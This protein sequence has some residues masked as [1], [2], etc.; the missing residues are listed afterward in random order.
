MA[1]PAEPTRPKTVSDL[2]R[3]LERDVSPRVPEGTEAIAHGGTALTLLGIKDSTKDVDFAFR[4]RD[5]FDAVVKAL[6]T[7]GY[8]RT[9]EMSPVPGEEFLRL[10]NAAVV[11]DVVDVR[12]PT[13]NGWRLTGAVFRNAI[14]IPLGNVRLVRP[15]RDAV[16]LFKTYP[17]RETD[18]A[19]LRAILAKD[20]PDEARVIALFDEQDAIHRA[21]LLEETRHEPLINILELRVRFAASIGLLEPSERGRIPGIARHAR[22]R[23]RELRLRPGLSTL[24][25]RLRSE[26]VAKWEDILAASGDRLRQQLAVKKGPKRTAPSQTRRR[27]AR[28]PR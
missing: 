5:G 28:G 11:V 7:M 14:V 25:R 15:D 22:N 16:F 20:P 6:T 8:R 18:L 27:D 12:F 3:W 10:E 24:I 4:T 1:A 2:T 17:L 26:T 21:E 23:F 13:W 9:M 19:D